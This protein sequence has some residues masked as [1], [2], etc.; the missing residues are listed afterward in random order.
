MEITLFHVWQRQFNQDP[1]WAA[2]NGKESAE[3]TVYTPFLTT[4]DHDYAKFICSNSDGRFVYTS[5]M[6]YYAAN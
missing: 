3:I 4:Q 5:Q 1:I 2:A 6:G